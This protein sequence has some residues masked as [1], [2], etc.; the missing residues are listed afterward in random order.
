MLTRRAGTSLARPLTTA[1]IAVL[2]AALASFIEPSTEQSQDTSSASRPPSAASTDALLSRAQVAMLKVAWLIGDWQG[3][4][5][6]AMAPGS[7]T[8]YRQTERVSVAAHQSALVIHGEG[9]ERDSLSGDWLVRFQAAGLLTYDAA[10]GRYRLMTAGGSGR[11]ITVDPEIRDD[12]FTWGF[13][14]GAVRIRYI[15]T[16]TPNDEWHEVG[17][18]SP[19]G[20]KTW[21]QFMG[22]TLRRR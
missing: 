18:M 8:V 15:V 14:A 7:R 2:C 3:E 22:M 19:D 4:G 1:I 17:E 10:E 21:R 9:T 16:R 11:A 5:W 13:D 20:G 6:I 12:G